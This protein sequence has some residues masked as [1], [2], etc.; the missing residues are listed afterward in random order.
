MG[1]LLFSSVHASET[2]R[3]L[4]S[5]ASTI[6]NIIDYSQSDFQRTLQDGAL[7]IATMLKLL[8]LFLRTLVNIAVILGRSVVG[9]RK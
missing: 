8:S 9:G 7:D 5:S 2:T 4:R 3:N 1:V 6:T